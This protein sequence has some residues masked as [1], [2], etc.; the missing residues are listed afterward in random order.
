MNEKL[1]AIFVGQSGIPVILA[2]ETLLIFSPDRPIQKIVLIESTQVQ[3][4]E[5]LYELDLRELASTLGTPP[6]YGPEERELMIPIAEVSSTWVSSPTF[7]R[8]SPG[9]AAEALLSHRH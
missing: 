3:D 4:G 9:L 6:I 2:E 7:R 8:Y 1:K 5:S